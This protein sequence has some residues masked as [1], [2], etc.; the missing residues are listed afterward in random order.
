MR[1]LLRKLIMWALANP[2]AAP[3]P[4]AAADLDALAAANK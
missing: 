3:A 1:N 2:S 4:N